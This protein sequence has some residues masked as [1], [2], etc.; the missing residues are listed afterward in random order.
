[1]IEQPLTL[2]LM[3]AFWASVGLVA[4]AYVGYP[5]LIALLAR[6]FGRQRRAVRHDGLDVPS[7]SILIA[8]YNEEKWIASRIRNALDQDYPADKLTVVVAS[9]GSSDRTV[10]IANQWSR[11][12]PGR[13]IVR[14]Y[15]ARSGKAAVLNRTVP[16]LPGQIVVLSD[17]NTFFHR[18]AVRNLARWF[19]DRSTTAVCGKLELIDPATGSNVDSLYWRFETFLKEREARLDALLGANGAIYAIRRE[20]YVAIPT[21]TI[22]DDLLIPLVIEMRHGGTLVYDPTATA[23]EE[24]PPH[25]SDEF[26]RRARIGAGGF[27]SLRRL[28]PL[29]LPTAGWTCLAFIS[30]KVLRWIAPLLLV[31]ALATN[32]ALAHLPGF[33]VLLALQAMFYLAAGLGSIT[34]GGSMLARALRLTTLFTS[35]NAALAVGFWRW[36]GG[37]QGAA[38][39][40]TAR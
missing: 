24:T 31:I 32:I 36:L 22:V 1:M 35:M 39:Q 4:Y 30:H 19:R 26:K 13:V 7:V 20:Q 29:M 6:A 10:Q 11:R 25:V 18:R 38:W 5:P 14:D 17:A 8:A 33:Q 12:H 37:S 15:A 27:Q 9:D 16:A 28:W 21:E 23:T 34:P 2:A 3:F 40:R